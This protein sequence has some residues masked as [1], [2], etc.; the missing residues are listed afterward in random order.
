[1][2]DAIGAHKRVS[3]PLG[4]TDGVTDAYEVPCG[5]WESNTL[6]GRAANALN[7]WAI[8]PSTCNG[9]VMIYWIF[10]KELKFEWMGREGSEKYLGGEEN[11]IKCKKF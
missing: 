10:F 6:S 5:C 9:F 1:M 11:M 7:Y 8:S 4:L 2:P 3:D